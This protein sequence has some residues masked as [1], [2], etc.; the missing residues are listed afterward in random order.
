[1]AI[2]PSEINEFFNSENEYN[3][4]FRGF[5][6]SGEFYLEFDIKIHVINIVNLV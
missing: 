1:M 3:Y 4:L 6:S 2:S 5:I